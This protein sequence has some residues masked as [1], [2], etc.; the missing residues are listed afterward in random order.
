MVKKIWNFFCSIR[1][2]LYLLL[3]VVLFLF[4]GS[5]QMTRRLPELSRLDRMSLFSWLVTVGRQDFSISYWLWIS[6]IS[7]FLLALNTTACTVDRLIVLFRT[8]FRIKTDVNMDFVAGLRNSCVFST[9]KPIEEVF[10]HAGSLFA[11]RRY[12]TAEKKTGN[13]WVLFGHRGRISLLGPHLAHVGFLVFLLGHLISSFV[14]EKTYGLRFYENQPKAVAGMEK[15]SLRLEEISFEYDPVSGQP[16]DYE[17]RFSLLAAG[18]KVKETVIGPNRPLFY[19]GRVLYQGPYGKEITHVQFSFGGA[20]GGHPISFTVPIEGE[21]TIPGTDMKL[22]LGQ[23]IPDFYI[24]PQGEISS[25]SYR[26]NN[27]AIPAFLY[28]RGELIRRAWFF[29]YNPNFKRLSGEGYN[30][31]LVKSK[32]RVYLEMDM[33]HNPGAPYALV[34][35]IL[36]LVGLFVGFLSSHRRLWLVCRD[37]GGETTFRL[38]GLASRNKDAFYRHIRRLY[39]QLT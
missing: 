28:R 3:S 6:I 1:L 16:V 17:S 5:A 21:T 8:Q 24:N 11:A 20:E 30:I 9:E 23:L 39:R 12:R 13:G 26:M 33:V 35:S 25:R 32:G 2:S 27:P 37:E 38:G 4:L 15:S 22:G 7:V 36:L 14:N 19:K 10:S 29:L 18:R 34:G 31:R